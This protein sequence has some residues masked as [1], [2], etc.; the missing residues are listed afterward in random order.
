MRNINRSFIAFLL[1]AALALPS[2][3]FA[4]GRAVP[5]GGGGHAGGG[6]GVAHPGPGPRPPVATPY[7]ATN[8]PPYYPYYPHYG[9]PR[10][11]YPYYGYG[12][13]YYGYPYYGYRPGWSF[14]FY[15]GYPWYVGPAGFGVG[16][17]YGYPGYPYYGGYAAYPGY[18]ATYGGVRIAVAQRNAEV[19]VDGY[20]AGIVNDFDGSFQQV[21][22]E[23]GPHR[24]EVRAQGFAPASFDVQVTPGRTVTYRT[25]L[26]EAQP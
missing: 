24:I 26:R 15:Y 11:G 13:P 22:L 16:F 21:N 3:A 7:H 19:Y 5:R 9:Y 20:Y 18:A 14:S 23:P 1:G 10:Y 25:A 12:Y 6:P 2:V 17:G 8:R 4:Q